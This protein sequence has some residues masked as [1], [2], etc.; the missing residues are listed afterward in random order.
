MNR[1]ATEHETPDLPRSAE[2]WLARLHSPAR[3][4][5]DEDAFERWRSADPEHAAAYAEV[6]YL[7]RNAALLGGDP[8]LRAVARAAR[9]DF[10][11][12][13]APRPPSRGWWLAA[14]VAAGLLLT[15]SIVQIMADR[16]DLG[17]LV[18]AA[19][20]GLPRAVTLSDGT[21]VALD[22]ETSLV[23]RFD[24]HRREV[25]LRN[26][27]AQFHV[28]PD[29]RRPFMV[30]AGGNLIRDIGTTFQVSRSAD[31][32]TVGLLEGRV[33]VSR[34]AVGH[35]WVSDLKPDQQLH[36]DASG[37]ASPVTP[38]DVDAARGWTQ[39]E[40][41]FSEQ[42]L[43]ELLRAMNRYSRT[44]LRLGDPSL[45]GLKVSGRFHAGDQLALAQALSQGWKLRVVRTGPGELT[46]LPAAGAR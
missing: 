44:Q 5:Q 1:Q 18:Y 20:V 46:L 13:R 11:R 35:A 8:M 23:A 12:R 43:D 6:E 2:E 29:A 14:G 24:G 33:S 38:L 19:G 32:V 39:G 10:T 9:R 21:E 30:V 4:P 42:R 22:A 16:P 34:D 31:G 28:A 37:Q 41:A 17:G 26:G 7:H 36:I 25:I 27:R 40:F 15:V 45:A 3:S